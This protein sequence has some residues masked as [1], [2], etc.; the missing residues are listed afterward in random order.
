MARMRCWRFCCCCCCCAFSPLMPSSLWPASP[1]PSSDDSESC[2]CPG[3][4]KMALAPRGRLTLAALSLPSGPNAPFCG[5]GECLEASSPSPSSSSDEPSSSATA[6]GA[7]CP[8]PRIRAAMPPPRTVLSPS[9]LQWRQKQ[10]QHQHVRLGSAQGTPS[11]PRAP[12]PPPAQRP[13]ATSSRSASSWRRACVRA[14]AKST[15]SFGAMTT[16]TTMSRSGC[17]GCARA[18]TSRA[19]R[20][21]TSARAVVAG[22]ATRTTGLCPS[23]G[24][25]LFYSPRPMFFC[26]FWFS[27]LCLLLLGSH[28]SVR[29]AVAKG[30]PLCRPSRR[31][32]LRAAY[33]LRM[34]SPHVARSSAP[35]DDNFSSLIQPNTKTIF[36]TKR[37]RKKRRIVTSP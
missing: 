12:P 26:F 32:R 27:F 21:R 13:N 19:Q 35:L 8:L 22:A 3:R 37:G 20:R 6:A 28:S 10:Q 24:F 33:F 31:A 36:Q 23:F 2:S 5:L 25:P 1:S 34:A 11:C 7:C 29:Q 4:A 17:R 16:M 14:T 9:S 30:V 18:K 15:A